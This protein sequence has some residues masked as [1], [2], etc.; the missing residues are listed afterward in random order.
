MPVFFII[1][2]Y[3]EIF[4]KYE[5][6]ICC[7]SS[8]K[9]QNIGSQSTLK[10]EQKNT[11]LPIHIS[12]NNNGN[13][14]KQQTQN[15]TTANNKNTFPKGTKYEK[16]LSSKFRYFDVFW[17]NPNQTNDFDNF[18]KCFER[19][20]YHIH[21]ELE[22]VKKFFMNESLTKWIVI[23]PGS[24]GEELIRNLENFECIKAFF[25]FC[26]NIKFHEN[27]TKKVKKVVCLTSNPEILCQKLIEFNK[28]FAFPN[29]IYKSKENISSN[30]NEIKYEK[31]FDLFSLQSKKIIDI[32]KQAN[33]KY[34][35]FCKNSIEYL[36]SEKF[37]EEHG[38][39]SLMP[40]INN[41]TALSMVFD[42]Y[43][44]L[45]H[46][47]SLEEVKKLLQRKIPIIFINEI[48]NTMLQISEELC[49]KILNKE[50]IIDEK[51]DLKILQIILIDSYCYFFNFSN[52]LD[53]SLINNYYHITNYFMD[54]DFCLKIFLL[55]IYT[56]LNTKSHNFYSELLFCLM[57]CDQRVN[58]LNLYLE[59]S[60]KPKIFNEKLRNVINDTLTIKDFI[61]LGDKRFHDK[62]KVIEKNIKSNSF[63]YLNIGQIRN[64]FKQRKKDKGSQIVP[65]YYFLVIRFEEYKENFENLLM[66][67]FFTGITFFVFLYIENENAKIH[68]N[69]IN[70][71][72]PTIFVYSTENI[73]NYLSQ[74]I[75]FIN[76]LDTTTFEE[77]AD[78]KIS[79]ITFKQCPKDQYQDGCFELAETFNVD[80]IKNKFLLKIDQDVDFTTEFSKNLYHIYKEHN[81]L[82]LFYSQNCIYFGWSRYP[83]MKSLN[84]CFVKRLLYMYCRE[85]AQSQKSFYRIVNEDLRSRV[86]S[87]I[88]RYINILALINQILQEGWLYFF[89]GKVY[90]ATKLDENLIMKLTPGVKM[91]NTTFWST[92]KDFKIAENMMIKDN[93]RNSFIICKTFKNNIDIDLEE[94]NPFN[95]K[96][97]L[98][99]PFTEFQLEKISLIKQYGKKVFIIELT[100]LGIKNFLNPNN[101]KI[102]KVNNIS[103]NK[104]ILN[105]CQKKGV[106]FEDLIKNFN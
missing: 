32:K 62:I 48:L 104:L 54:I 10:N 39:E 85:E 64:Y 13:N 95:E 60:I 17:Y 78:F 45:L 23:T 72:F 69:I 31:L 33:I 16:E 98:F 68:K 59:N 14:L 93:F 21:H 79:K 66:L 101:M 55:T 9:D 37:E 58:F 57:T 41:L 105:F 44:F 90:R 103:M 84:I 29:F 56:K 25:V 91:V 96:E 50:N 4:D 70:F 12:P 47:L 75:Y 28:N 63:Q 99:L 20:R 51:N 71:V 26:G 34:L 7:P 22:T 100:E 43:P 30:T 73:L 35:N 36:N 52:L 2:I 102:E 19:V 74:K 27:W 92:S 97:V 67:T 76:F 89:E 82:D 1:Y 87:K 83:E 80:L 61:I 42:Q 106:K 46:L 5:M 49:Y 86:P 6:G 24:K 8:S 53:I 15:N 3:N 40:L 94:L 88:Y 65:Y 18:R 81:A 11:I 38:F 77:I